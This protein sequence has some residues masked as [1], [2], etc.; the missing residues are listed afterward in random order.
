MMFVFVFSPRSIR[1]LTL[2]RYN[3]PKAQCPPMSL[4]VPICPD[5]G[6]KDDG[7]RGGGHRPP[8]GE[9]LDGA[10]ARTLSHLA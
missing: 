5:K 1:S 4:N 10:F 8:S 2:Q 3:I 7:T 9:S 6:E